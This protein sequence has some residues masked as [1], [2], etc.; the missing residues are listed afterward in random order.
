MRRIGS[1]PVSHARFRNDGKNMAGIAC[2]LPAQIAYR[3]TQ[4]VH[5]VLILCAAPD[6]VNDLMVCSHP[7][8]VMNQNIQKMIFS[9]G[10]SD[11]FAAHENLSPVE[12]DSEIA[13]HEGFA[14]RAS[15]SPP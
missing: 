7:S 12:I 6:L 3:D 10:Q 9:S 5:G 2:Q 4:K 11:L 8:G 15:E 1:K 14:L 13:G